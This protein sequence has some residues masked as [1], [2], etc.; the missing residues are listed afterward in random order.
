MKN[1]KIIEKDN[2]YFVSLDTD[3][4]KLKEEYIKKY[5]S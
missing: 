5:K 1:I 4:E 3:I 2:K